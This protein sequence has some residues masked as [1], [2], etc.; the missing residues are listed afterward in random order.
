[1]KIIWGDRG[2][3]ACLEQSARLLRA[4]ARVVRETSRDG[5]LGWSMMR[6]VIAVIRKSEVDGVYSDEA[7]CRPRIVSAVCGLRDEASHALMPEVI[8]IATTCHLSLAPS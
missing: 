3:G 6:C 1:M 5:I 2:L 7:H 4:V 8:T